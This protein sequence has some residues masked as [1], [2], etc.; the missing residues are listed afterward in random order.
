[1]L[2]RLTERR[3]R[4]SLAL[5][6]FGCLLALGAPLVVNLSDAYVAR[7]R[8][9]EADAW[10]RDNRHG[11]SA[12]AGAVRGT[13]VVP[14]RDGYLLEIPKIGLRA[15]VR[16]LEPAVFL[17]KNTPI[18][19]RYGLGQV[20]YTRELRNGSPGADGTAVIAG[21]RTTSGAPFRRLDRLRR[22]DLIVV[23]KG[24]VEQ[25]WVVESSV[26]VP[27]SAINVIRS[28]PGTRRL[29]IMACNPPFSAK[30]RL[31][32]HAHLKHETVQRVAQVSAVSEKR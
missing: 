3:H 31:V 26:I 30:E 13:V 22:G 24:G 12:P 1:V 19:R 10:T 32:V 21:H 20:P 16:E 4:A 25:Q 15:V 6:V 18:L 11:S 17:G 14:D 9:R 28:R 2:A 5:I 8:V 23:R 7:S 27:P 29:A